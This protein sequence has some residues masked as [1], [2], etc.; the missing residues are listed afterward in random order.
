LNILTKI[1]VILVVVVGLF[2]S[3]VLVSHV[4][5]TPNWK[6]LYQSEQLR[7]EGHQTQAMNTALALYRAQKN[8]EALRAELTSVRSSDGEAIK[9]KDIAFKDLQTAKAQ[10]DANLSA[11][12]AELTN[13]QTLLTV[14]HDEAVSKEK[15]IT[16]MREVVKR[17]NEEN[18]AMGKQ[19]NQ[20]SSEAVRYVQLVRIKDITIQDLQE[21]LTRQQEP[22]VPGKPAETASDDNVKIEGQITAAA[23]NTASINVGSSKGIK[24]GMRLVVYRDN[25]NSVQVLGHLRISDVDLSESAGIVEGSVGVRQGDRVT[26]SVK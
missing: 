24:K 9:N 25:N 7:S 1:S 26:T 23:G 3:V 20:L 8:Y 16:D 10:T 22:K 13:L 4:T 21:Q 17:L 12:K 11:F 18:L 15:I 6:S 5:T 14:T 2:L 19:V